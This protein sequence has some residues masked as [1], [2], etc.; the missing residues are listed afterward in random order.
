MENLSL[1]PCGRPCF[2]PAQR[3][4]CLFLSEAHKSA[5]HLEMF[6]ILHVN[7]GFTD[8]NVLLFLSQILS[9]H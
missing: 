2:L 4:D 8:L 5:H 3:C 9:L 1:P 6:F 7:L